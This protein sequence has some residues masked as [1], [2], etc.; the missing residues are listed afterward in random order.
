M[1]VDRLIKEKS[2]S[3]LLAESREK[4]C[5]RPAAGDAMRALTYEELGAE[6]DSFSVQLMRVG[7]KQGGHRGV[8]DESDG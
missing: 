2:L 3:E 5:D 6:V 8:Y 1:N 4:Y 7:I